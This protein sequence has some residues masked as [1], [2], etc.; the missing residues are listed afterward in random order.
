LEKQLRAKY[1]KFIRKFTKPFDNKE[2][3]REIYSMIRECKKIYYGT[4]NKYI[5]DYCDEYEEEYDI[6]R[7][8]EEVADL[9]DG[10]PEVTYT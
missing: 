3:Y 9:F 6:I 8:V 7:A 10:I 2:N 5:I 4:E 1:Y